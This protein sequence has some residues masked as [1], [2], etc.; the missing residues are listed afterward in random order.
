MM[1]LL[2][3]LMIGL[4]VY[5]CTL[6]KAAEG[7]RFYLIP[8]VDGIKENGIW[9]VISAAMAQSFF[10]LSVGIGSIAIFGSYI[11]KERSLAGEAL[12]SFLRRGFFVIGTY[13]PQTLAITA[14]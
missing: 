5:A 7:L 2:L 6:S 3:G 9:P 1:I 8:N 10:T 14:A 11:D 4:A 12:T 13:S